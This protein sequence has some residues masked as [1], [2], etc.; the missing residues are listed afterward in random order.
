M[1]RYCPVCGS[2]MVW[3]STKFVL[4]CPDC[5][6]EKAVLSGSGPTYWYAW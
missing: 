5:G 4:K 1:V 3:D 2:K 6:Y